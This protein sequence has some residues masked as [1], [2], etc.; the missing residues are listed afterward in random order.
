MIIDPK[1]PSELK[2]KLK[3]KKLVL[4]GFG[5]AG[6]NIAKWCDENDIDYVFVDRD[7]MNKQKN[8]DK[9]IYQ[10]DDLPVK[11]P[12]SNIVISSIIYFDEIKENLLKMGLPEENLLSYSEFMPEV[13]TWKELEKS[14]VWGM[15][16]ERVE[17]ISEL[18]PD[19]VDSVADYGEG[20]I[21]LR[22]FLSQ[23]IKYYPFDYIKRSELTVLCDFDNDML[24]NI[25]ADV[26]VC[27]ATL[28]FLKKAEDLIE[29]ICKHTQKM[30]ILS[31]VTTDVFSNV[32]GRRVSG[33]LNDFSEAEIIHIMD[34]NGFEFF[35]KENDPAN[36][37]DKI[38]MF[39]KKQE[40]AP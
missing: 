23:N 40:V 37:I 34:K 31:Y 32:S 11:F 39:R 3:E 19:D 9:P 21:N 7:A 33:Y 13:I 17:K 8:T 35:G 14:T 29:H 24:P 16:K 26:S 22:N 12:N 5:G 38:Y 20:K 4:Y 27:T 15:N 10:P 18:I 2:K 6:I 36:S 30:I 25:D 28:V 1:E